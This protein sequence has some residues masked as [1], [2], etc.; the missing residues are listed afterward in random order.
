MPDIVVIGDINVDVNFSIPAYPTPGNEAVATT[1]Q[2]HTGGSAV[3]TAIA[4][5]KMD[6]NVGFIG[7]VGQDNLGDKVLADLSASGVDCAYVQTDPTVSTGMIF[8]AVTADG[9]RTM[10][11]A[12]G[13]NVFTEAKAINSAC[14]AECRWIHLSGYSFLSHHQYETVLFALDQAENSPYTRVSLDIGPEP[15][16]R[17]RTKILETLPR[18]DIV[19]PNKTELTLLSEGLPID[20]SLDYLLDNGANAV[21]TKC[22]PEGSLLA[23]ENIRVRLPAFDIEVK[24]STGAGDSFDAGVVFGRLIGLTWEAS[25]ALGNALGGLVTTQ[26]GSGADSISRTA[27]A[28]LVEKHLF[29]PEW[30]PVQFAL[31]ELTA[32]FESEQGIL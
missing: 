32:Y 14:F 6:M 5:S 28:K 3:N 15:A 25:V 26:N 21:V 9:E 1:A 16:L 31:E 22:G 12:R 30:A 13:A 11:S 7:R 24:D 8:I 2:M 10:F 17:A 20:P 27:V 23:T 18:L 4:L 29:H 19:F